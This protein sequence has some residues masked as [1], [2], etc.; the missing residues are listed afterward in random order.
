[1]CAYSLGCLFADAHIISSAGVVLT[2][3]SAI[4]PYTFNSGYK[5][6]YDIDDSK[7][8]IV[9]SLH[10]LFT[11]DIAAWKHICHPT[12]FWQSPPSYKLVT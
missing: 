2:S 10:C 4:L 11:H 3:Y 9:P 8:A 7:G 5:N 12:I 1:V 6:K